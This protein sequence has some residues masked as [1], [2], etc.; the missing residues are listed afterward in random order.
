MDIPGGGR[1][2]MP[3]RQICR[4]FTMSWLRN[5]ASSP[6]V[7]RFA[8]K[9]GFQ[10]FRQSYWNASRIPPSITSVGSTADKNCSTYAA[11]TAYYLDILAEG[12]GGTGGLGYSYS[13]EEIQ[14]LDAALLEELR[15]AVPEGWF[16]CTA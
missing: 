11:Q 7:T 8:S 4:L 2:D 3:L 1:Q 13:D 14:G 15:D 5:T 9:N 6:C 16:P 10:F 12:A